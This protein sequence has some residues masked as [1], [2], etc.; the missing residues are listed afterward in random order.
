MVLS[1][2]LTVTTGLGGAT[3]NSRVVLINK[4]KAIRI[5]LIIIPIKNKGS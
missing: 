5:V 1:E 2:I 3:A 4:Y